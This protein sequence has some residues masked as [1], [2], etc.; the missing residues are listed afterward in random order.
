MKEG[1]SDK[2]K[3]TEVHSGHPDKISN[4]SGIWE[5]CK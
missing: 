4:E 1:N 3:I 5:K 2:L